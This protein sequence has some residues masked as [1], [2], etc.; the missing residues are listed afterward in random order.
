MEPKIA[1]F[2]PELKQLRILAK[3]LRFSQEKQHFLFFLAFENS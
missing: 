2:Y 3:F 1:S